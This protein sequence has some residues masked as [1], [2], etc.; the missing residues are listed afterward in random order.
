MRIAIVGGGVSG[1]TVAHLLHRDHEIT[2]FE[3]DRRLGGHAHTVRVDSGRDTLHLDT[4]FIVF[5]DRNYPNFERLLARIGVPSQ[6]SDMSFGVSDG[7]SF[8]YASHSLDAVFANR[9]NALN[10]MFLR[11]LAEIPRFQRAAKALLR[12]GDE[13]VSLSAW[14]REQRFSRYFIERLIVPQAAAVWSADPAQMSTFPALFLA[15]FFDNHG[16]LS[17]R[18]RPNWRTV[19]GGSERYVEALVEGFRERVYLDAPV[20]AITRDRDGV[21]VSVAGVE[22]LDFDHVVIATHSDQ[23]LELLTD[24]TRRE[25]E[26]LE[27]IPYQENEAVL[28][29]DRSLLPQR[30]AAWASWNYH[31]LVDDGHGGSGRTAVTYNLNRLQSIPSEQQFCV[32]LNLVERIDP[33]LVLERITY[34]HPVYTPEGMAAQRRVAEI[35]GPED[36]TH[37]CGAYWG[38][39]FH[40]DG[41]NSALRVAESFGAHL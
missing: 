21:T 17:L 37:F 8:E 32:T 9:A 29:T 27:A 5:N 35:S 36:R 16:M 2:V 23:A 7:A 33:R 24:P 28:H 41:V 22:S 39:G 6:P 30:R 15:H 13:R 1:L 26:I 11:M 14:L 34:A 18:G 31:L 4:G 20:T 40:E 38:W 25:R 12:S 3:A 10:P 19:T